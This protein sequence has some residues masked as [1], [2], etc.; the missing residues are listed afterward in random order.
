MF[1]KYTWAVSL[2]SLLKPPKLLASNLGKLSPL[3]PVAARV[4]PRGRRIGWIEESL[5]CCH[6][7]LSRKQDLYIL[8]SW[9]K[10]K[11]TEEVRETRDS[12]FEDEDTPYTHVVV[13][14]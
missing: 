6:C 2:R 4:T 9:T 8:I 5:V 10:R 11:I 12:E 1:S 13:L 14:R 3:P 7:T